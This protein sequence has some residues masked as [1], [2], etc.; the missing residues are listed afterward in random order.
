MSFRTFSIWSVAWLVLLGS[1]GLRASE[2]TTI[3]T[4]GKGVDPSRQI[5]VEKALT[6]AVGKVNP[7]ALKSLNAARSQ[8]VQQSRTENGASQR[9]TDVY[10]EV[11]REF[12]QATK[13]ILKQWQIVSETKRGDLFE[14]VVAAEVFRLKESAQMNRRRISVLA[15]VT[16]DQ[17]F[18]ILAKDALE[19]AL[20]KSRKFAIL[21]DNAS[22]TLQQFV[23]GVRQNGRIEDLVRLEGTA[24][25]ELVTVISIDNLVRSGTRLAGQMGVEVIDYAT[26]QIKYKNSVNILLHSRNAA[27]TQQAIR[28]VALDLSRQ[29]L[30][31]VYPPM[32][33]GW[34]GNAM[35]IAQ[36]DG[37]FRRGDTVQIMESLGGL[38]DPYTGE[39]LEEN[40]I[41]RCQAVIRSVS[42][43]VSVAQPR[44]DCGSPFLNG[45]IE[46][47]ALLNS[48]IFIAQRKTYRRSSSIYNST[49]GGGSGSTS[50]SDFNGL[51]NTD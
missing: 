37:F 26:G 32:V 16:S 5:A 40:L 38:K 2:I 39:F 21:Q 44:G 35:T 31:N 23:N 49:S 10:K 29:L 19:E 11:E 8:V 3:P 41:A 47:A 27:R 13:G 42:S 20:V 22:R 14:V 43:R 50:S 18:A 17:D 45:S 6:E 9:S 28:T 36:G 4:T 12:S 30:A 25:P 15:D 33:I 7:S 34:N 1:T 46:Q 24:A 48:A 51:F